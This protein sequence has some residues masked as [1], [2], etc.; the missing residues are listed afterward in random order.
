MLP[1]YLSDFT[2]IYY[3]FWLTGCEFIH[4]SL[5]EKYTGHIFTVN[6]CHLVY[7]LYISKSQLLFCSYLKLILFLVRSN[8]NKTAWPYG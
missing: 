1:L 3:R 7:F 8:L 2:G 6:E 4:K 5:L